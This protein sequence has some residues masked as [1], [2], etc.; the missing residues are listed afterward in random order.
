M[1]NDYSRP[2]AAPFPRE[3]AVMIARKAS[4]MAQC[5]EDQ[6]VRQMVRDAQRALDRGVRV[7]E[8]AKEMDLPGRQTEGS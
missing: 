4:A 6:A 1:K 7:E 3:L 2:K 8:I 5:L